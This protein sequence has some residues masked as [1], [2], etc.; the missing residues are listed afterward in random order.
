MKFSLMTDSGL[1]LL[2]FIASASAQVEPHDEQLSPDEIMS[3]LSD[4]DLE[5][6]LYY[7]CDDSGKSSSIPM[8]ACFCGML[9]SIPL[10]QDGL[11][12]ISHTT[13]QPPINETEQPQSTQAPCLNGLADGTYPCREVDL[14]SNLPLSTFNSTFANDIWGW[15]ETDSK[16][17]FALLGLREGTAFVEVTDSVNPIFWG[18]LLSPSSIWRDIKVYKNHA[19][20]VSE[21]TTHGMVIFDLM[22]LLSTAQPGTKYE[23]D[24]EYNGVGNSHNIAINEDSGFAYLLG[25]NTCSGG[26]H[27]VDISNPQ[28]PVAA[29]CYSG[30]GYTHDAQCVNYL[31]PDVNYQG[32]EICFCCNTDTVTIVD[33]TD[34]LKPIQLSRTPYANH[35]YTH[36]GW[37]STNQ[38]HFV[39]GDETDEQ[40]FGHATRTM[41]LDVSNLQNPTNFQEFFG[42]TD[43]IDHNLYIVNHMGNHDFSYQANYRAGLQ[44]YEILDYDTADFEL[45]GNFDIYP[46][47][48]AASFNGA[49]SVYPFF[50]SG[51][52]IV[53]GIAEGLF[54]LKPTF[55]DIGGST[56]TPTTS[57]SLA[58]TKSPSSAPTIGQ[59]DTFNVELVVGFDHW[60]EDFSYT[61][62]QSDGPVDTDTVGQVVS[63]GNGS[64]IP[65]LANHTWSHSLAA[66][67]YYAFQLFDSWGDGLNTSMSSYFYASRPDGQGIFLN[68]E[69]TSNGIHYGEASEK[70]WFYMNSAGQAQLIEPFPTGSPT[71]TASPIGPQTQAPTSIGSFPSCQTCYFSSPL[72]FDLAHQMALARSC[73]LASLEDSEQQNEVTQIIHELILVDK[74]W[75][76][77]FQDS[78]SNAWN[79]TDGTPF[80]GTLWAVNQPNGLSERGAMGE[81][82]YAAVG[83]VGNT[84]IGLFDEANA[85]A[86]PSVW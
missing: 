54:V 59:D 18:I 75:V 30:D 52:V 37:L 17:E 27:M 24:A 62:V 64:G 49:W 79:W 25:T 76:G 4:E 68:S 42:P 26:L 1:L 19:F 16:R 45:V 44:V 20:I 73:N 23:K 10:D 86:L 36:Q 34:K 12:L 28:M 74:F 80:S 46:F 66:P 71:P 67:S 85:A 32:R 38:G 39:F 84:S 47:N 2:L 83:S 29:G 13:S 50:P 35:G 8:A 53:S 51:T 3:Q 55:L 56:A 5:A 63:Q 43:A 69:K 60:P 40:S 61:L 7:G 31:G 78:A 48:D 11:A 58:P 6:Y 41:V 81:T 77:G 9:S 21:A 82:R 33:V 65:G 70:F 15:T 72:P 22:R 57:L 14:Q